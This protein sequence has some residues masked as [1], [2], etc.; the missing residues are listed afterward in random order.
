M[1]STALDVA[2]HAYGSF[3]VVEERDS[4]LALLRRSVLTYESPGPEPRVFDESAPHV[5]T[6]LKAIVGFRIEITRMEGKWKLSQNHSEVRRRKVIRA[7]EARS[8]EGSQEIA[9]RM[10]EEDG[11][12]GVWAALPAPA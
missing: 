9:R 5:E 11:Q 1:V 8:D 6:I 2:V 4:L 12:D 3:H 10:R 7:L